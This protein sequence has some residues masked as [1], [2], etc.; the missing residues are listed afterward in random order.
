MCGSHAAGAAGSGNAN[1]IARGN[2]NLT[3]SG[4]ANMKVAAARSRMRTDLLKKSGCKRKDWVAASHRPKNA[5]LI[6][7]SNT[8]RQLQ[9]VPLCRTGSNL[10]TVAD[11]SA[12]QESQQ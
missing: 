10:K 11:C 9:T 5:N 4:N 1:L 7:G 6:G 2:R 12:L 8:K 3:P